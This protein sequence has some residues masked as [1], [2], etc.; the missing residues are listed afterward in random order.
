MATF[1]VNDILGVGFKYEQ[2]AEDQIAPTP[3]GTS[4][5]IF[6]TATWGPIG[7]PTYINGGLRDFKNRFG[8]AGTTADDGWDAGSYHFKWS[9]LGY[10]TRINSSANPARRSY[11]EVSNNSTK[12]FLT[13]SQT[14]N[15]TLRIYS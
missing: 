10:F 11:K 4:I 12:A 13:G 5:A 7:V 6:G 9:S 14:L 15:S 2:T 8:Y 1:T 3:T